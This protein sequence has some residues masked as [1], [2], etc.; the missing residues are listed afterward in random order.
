MVKVVGIG[1][2]YAFSAVVYDFVFNYAWDFP[3][4]HYCLSVLFIIFP[5]STRTDT[6]ATT[7]LMTATISTINQPAEICGGT[8]GS[9]VGVV[10]GSEVSFEGVVVGVGAGVA[11][12]VV[13]EVGVGVGLGSVIGI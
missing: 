3:S 8:S 2:D 13:V 4:F 5:L 11:V 9:G 6:I 12:G 1:Q 7:E 10:V